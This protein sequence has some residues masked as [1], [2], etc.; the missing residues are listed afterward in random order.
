MGFLFDLGSFHVMQSMTKH[1]MRTRQGVRLYRG[2]I[3]HWSDGITRLPAAKADQ[4]Q[5]A[6]G[7]CMI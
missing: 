4:M 7:R 1:S 5:S 6:G 3:C 2:V